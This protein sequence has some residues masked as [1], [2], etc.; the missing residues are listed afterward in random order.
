MKKY[1][2]VI[3]KYK[4]FV[5]SVILFMAIGML[6]S[7]ADAFR[8]RPKKK[9][10]DLVEK[11]RDIFFNETFDG[12]GRTCGTCHPAENNLTIDPK[13]IAKL[14]GDDPLFIA[15]NV[16]ELAGLERPILM[17]QFGLILENLDGFDPADTPLDERTGLMRCVP[18]LF[19][20]RTSIQ[21]VGEGPTPFGTGDVSG[22]GFADATGWSGDGSP[23][24][25]AIENTGVTKEYLA[26]HGI[27]LDGS[28]RMFIQG[29]IVQHYPKTLARIPDQDFRLATDEELEAVEAFMLSLGRQE[30]IDLESLN[31][32]SEVV[33][34]GKIL[35]LDT[36]MDPDPAPDS[37]GAKC[38]I[39]HMNAGA[40]NSL[41]PGNPNANLDT[42]I[43]DQLDLPAVLV[44]PTTP[45]DDGLLADQ[46]DGT[47]NTPSLIEAAD[48]PPFF[49]NNSANTIE[50]AVGFF[51]SPAFN[52]SP[53]GQAIGGIALDASQ[54]VAV[55][56]LLRTLNALENIRNSIDQ[57]Q[58]VQNDRFFN[59]RE[60]L[61]G[62]I[63]DNEDAIEVLT[64][65]E[66]V[67]FDDAIKFLK[68]A[69]QLGKKAR[70]AGG[71]KRNKLLNKAIDLLE[72]A[73]AE[74]IE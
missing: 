64:G 10:I 17:R 40:R 38:Q 59:G 52:E 63:A 44:D 25:L 33:Q 31:F 62:P 5:F 47:F 65:S 55:A 8:R 50:A 74:I 22:A 35:F 45:V 58:K 66:Y 60:R 43:E 16:P 46:G 19:G 2:K 49:H 71:R 29:A 53:P 18:H 70:F 54:I 27:V 39:C 15:E 12:N 24:A 23:S 68:E 14:P 1:R 41:F 26:E 28:L 11:G 37:P 51:N 6:W 48:T 57:Y 3:K 72:A 67:L 61:K 20:L 13:F 36:D 56:S 73:R 30:D 9:P 42:N 21:P 69:H 7:T 34:R 32:N 4:L